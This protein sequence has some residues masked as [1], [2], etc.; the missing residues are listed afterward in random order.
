VRLISANSA[1]WF[2]RAR[3]LREGLGFRLL[4]SSVFLV[5]PALAQQNPETM[6]PDQNKAKARQV[7][8]QSVEAMGGPLF[9]D[10]SESV[11]DGRMAKFD[12]NGGTMGYSMVHTY[13]KYPDKNRTE[14]IVKTTKGG[15]FAVLWGNLPV[16]GGDFIQLFDG[17]KG[18][19]MDKSGVNEADATVVEE[20]QASLKRQVRN[21]LLNRANEEGVFLY[22]GGI[23]ISEM[24]EVEWVDFT[25]NDDRK[26]RIAIDRLSHLPLRTIATTP[27]EDM[28]DKDEDVT[29][30]S[31][32][33]PLQGVQTPMQI[34]REHNGSRTLQIFYDACTNAPNLPGDFFT[35]ASL[36]KKFKDSGGK[37]KAQK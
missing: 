23:G 11:C 1:V 34:N 15:I 14:Y 17:D 18:W 27:N 12:R 32:Y 8:K 7:L 30:Y 3:M 16:K 28:H 20:F 36:Q 25:D 24:R 26:V 9:R 21:L 4:C 13:W 35:E 29:I 10:Q 6:D 5:V 33:Q 19:T 22:Y 37:V 31:N 2:R